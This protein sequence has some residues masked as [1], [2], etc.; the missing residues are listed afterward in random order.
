MY[1][2]YKY[3]DDRI[4]GFAAPFLLGAL[5]GGTAV[6]IFNPYRPRPYYMPYPPR[7][8]RPFPPYYGPF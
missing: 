1:N 6:G 8:P 2:N 7:P 5:T 4:I 3:K